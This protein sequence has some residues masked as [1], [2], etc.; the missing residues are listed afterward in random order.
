MGSCALR[1]KDCRCVCNCKTEKLSKSEKSL[2]PFPSFADFPLEL[3]DMGWADSAFFT[4]DATAGTG[5]VTERGAAGAW[6]DETA[7]FERSTFDRFD[8]RSIGGELS[9]GGEVD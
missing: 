2:D 1:S 9:F 7:G 5:D 4:D 8:S 6:K 3:F